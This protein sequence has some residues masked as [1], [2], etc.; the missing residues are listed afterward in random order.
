MNTD[1][2]N[3]QQLEAQLS[4]PPPP[5]ADD[6]F[7][8]GVV[9]TLRRAPQTATGRP[10]WLAAL[11]WGMPWPLL[12]IVFSTGGVIATDLDWP[13]DAALLLFLAGGCV[14]I[15]MQGNARLRI[16]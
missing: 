2:I 1:P 12:A 16:G 14:L 8:D 3:D 13:A 11:V 4:Q 10:G 5:I 6:G 15:Q 7:S 9:A